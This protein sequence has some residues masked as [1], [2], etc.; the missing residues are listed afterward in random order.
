MSEKLFPVQEIGSLPKAPWLIAYLRGKR[1]EDKDLEHLTKWSKTIDFE[2]ES[3]AKSILTQP[4]TLDG[5]ERIRN[6]GRCSG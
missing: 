4:K 6:L 1:V 5:E 3:E 2:N